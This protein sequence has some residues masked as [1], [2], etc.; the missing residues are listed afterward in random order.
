[1]EWIAII[2]FVVFLLGIGI[3]TRDAIKHA[4]KD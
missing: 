3:V 2:V 4:K 1:M